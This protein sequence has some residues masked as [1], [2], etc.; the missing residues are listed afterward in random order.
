MRYWISCK[1]G[2]VITDDKG[3]I[4]EDHVGR[5][6]VRPIPDASWRIVGFA[7]RFNAHS[8]VTLAEAAEGADLGHGFVHDEDH[9]TRRVWMQPM[10]RRV[11]S[12]TRI[13]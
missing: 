3:N 11:L 8:L 4:L 2:H 7:R 5:H 9:G 13:P 6:Y 1:D 10:G 12:V